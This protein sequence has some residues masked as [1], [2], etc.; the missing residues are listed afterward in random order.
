MK[1]FKK[2]LAVEYFFRYFLNIEH[3]EDYLHQLENTP[4][5][6]LKNLVL[7]IS[8]SVGLSSFSKVQLFVLHSTRNWG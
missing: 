8:E 5:Y 6:L 2:S 3:R 1:H 7:E 4:R